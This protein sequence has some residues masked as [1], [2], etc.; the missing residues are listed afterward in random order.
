MRPLLSQNKSPLKQRIIDHLKLMANSPR[1]QIKK[2][3][4]GTVVSA[5]S[6]SIIVL[7]AQLENQWLFYF[8]SVAV[9]VGILYALPGY[10]GIWIWRMRD[11]IFRDDKVL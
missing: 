10:L 5:V 9:I 4:I 11:T 8:L 6:M 3:V 2:L 1:T 7:T